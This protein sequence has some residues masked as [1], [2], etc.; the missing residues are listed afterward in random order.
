MIKIMKMCYYLERYT[1]KQTSFKYH[2]AHAAPYSIHI[3]LGT[4]VQVL[5]KFLFVRILF[6]CK[7]VTISRPEMMFFSDAHELGH[8]ILSNVALVFLFCSRAVKLD[9]FCLFLKTQQK[10]NDKKLASN[11]FQIH[12]DEIHQ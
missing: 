5:Y 12:H 10:N 8:I 1:L 2:R 6:I 7:V 11:C 3:L 4:S 9:S